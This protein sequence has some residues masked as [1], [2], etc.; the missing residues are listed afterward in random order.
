M[1]RLLEQAQ[2]ELEAE[3]DFDPCGIR[4]GGH[5]GDPA[6]LAGTAREQA[7]EK[8][9]RKDQRV[10]G[11][12]SPGAP[13][14]VCSEPRTIR[15]RRDR[16][17]RVGKEVTSPKLLYKQEPSYTPGASRC[18]RGRHSCA[19]HRSLAGWSGSQHPGHPAPSTRS[20][21]GGDS[22]GARMALCAWPQVGRAGQSGGDH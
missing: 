21:L 22:S 19:Y 15:H 12:R 1:T 17:H 3:Q 13:V 18:R 14:P 5:R 10:E 9:G 4:Y 20:V 16:P 11:D 8:V 6:F 7:A 2:A